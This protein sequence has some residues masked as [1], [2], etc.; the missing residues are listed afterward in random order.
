MYAVFCESIRLATYSTRLQAESFILH[1]DYD[2]RRG[3]HV[4]VL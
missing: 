2:H 1:Y 4:V 3:Y